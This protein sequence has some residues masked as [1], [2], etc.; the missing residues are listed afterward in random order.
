MATTKFI[1]STPLLPTGE[2]KRWSETD[3]KIY[4][5][6]VNISRPNVIKVYNETIGGVDRSDQNIATYRIY[7]RQ[8]KWYWP[9]VADSLDG[10]IQNAWLL[11]RYINIFFT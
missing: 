10:E 6:M 5:K 2:V 11:H 3:K 4:K 1:F 9:L 7:M 8:K